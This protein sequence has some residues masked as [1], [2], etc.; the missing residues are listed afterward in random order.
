[1]TWESSR[2]VNVFRSAGHANDAFAMR[3]PSVSHRHRT[4]ARA[5]DG[6]AV[7][8]LHTKRPVVPK[9]VKLIPTPALTWFQYTHTFSCLQSYGK[10][11]YVPKGYFYVLLEKCFREALTA[12]CFEATI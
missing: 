3:L 6:R 4:A 8:S 1:M 9:H 2:L 11:D 7:S 12:T 10:V 5:Q